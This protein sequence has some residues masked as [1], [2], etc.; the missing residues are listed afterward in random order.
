MRLLLVGPPG[1][2]KGT[3]SRKLAERLGVPHIASGELLREAIARGTEIGLK[4]A[5]YMDRGDL[6]PDDLMIWFIS[7]KLDALD[8]QG[9]VLDG[10][11][12]TVNQAEALDKALAEQGLPLDLVIHLFTQD[13]ELIRRMTGR[14]TCP[15]CH[16]T[17]HMIYDPP[18]TDERCDDD[19]TPLVTRADDS[20]ETVKHRLEVYRRDTED[21]IRYYTESGLLVTLDGLG[22]PAEVSSR[23][24]E[25]LEQAR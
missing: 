5:A 2:G 12:R 13:E 24:D 4:A 7:T 20:Y 10:F 1:A 6:V 25:A 11:P 22:E 21:L 16:R 23:I 18:A 8:A 17:Y 15:T 14:R 19:Q 9:F 3:Q